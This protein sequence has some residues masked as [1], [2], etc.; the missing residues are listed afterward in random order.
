[1]T[2]R[3]QLEAAIAALEAQRPILGDAV[4]EAGLRAMRGQLAQFQPAEDQRK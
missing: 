3:A 4:V 2:E 1:M